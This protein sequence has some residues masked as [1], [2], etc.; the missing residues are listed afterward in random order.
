MRVFFSCKASGSHG[1]KGMH[2]HVKEE[3][4]ISPYGACAEITILLQFAR[5][6]FGIFAV[7]MDR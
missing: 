7:T 6:Y 5:L 3:W 1:K 4:T 2:I